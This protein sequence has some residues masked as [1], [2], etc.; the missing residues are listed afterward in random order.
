MVTCNIVLKI[1]KALSALPL[2]Q[3]ELVDVFDSLLPQQGKLPFY[4]VIYQQNIGLTAL[5]S[6]NSNLIC[7]NAWAKEYKPASIEVSC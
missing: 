6:A 1:Q 4:F 5:S 7:R 2:V 3:T